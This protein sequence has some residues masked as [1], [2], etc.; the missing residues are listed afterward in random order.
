MILPLGN[1]F[2]SQCMKHLPILTWVCVVSMLF[3]IH[4][5]NEGTIGDIVGMAGCEGALRQ[6]SVQA[7]RVA[8]VSLVIPGQ[9]MIERA[10][11]SIADTP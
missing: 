8:L 2:R 10:H 5:Y 4:L 11:A 9:K 1:I 7:S 3:F 6:H